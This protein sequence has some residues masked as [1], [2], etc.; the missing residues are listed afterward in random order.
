M[1]PADDPRLLT[2]LANA[3]PWQTR[4]EVIERELWFRRG[5]VVDVA[6]AA[7]LERNLRRLGL[8]ADVVVRLADAGV[9]GQ[10]DREIATRDRLTLNFGAGAP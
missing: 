10:V 9:S 7:E 5:D 8:F 3:L 6:M 1:F 2:R 4:V